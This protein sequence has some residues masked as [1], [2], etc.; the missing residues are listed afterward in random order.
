M[1]LRR[2]YDNWF[3]FLRLPETETRFSTLPNIWYFFLPQYIYMMMPGSFLPFLKT[4]FTIFSTRSIRTSPVHY[5]ERI[6]A[7]THK[8]NNLEKR[9]L[10]WT[11]KFKSIEEVPTYIAP[12]IMEKTRN[13]IRIRVANIMMA[14]TLVICLL[15]AISGKRARDSGDSVQKRNLD[16]HK[17]LKEESIAMDKKSQN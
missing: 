13:K 17:Q 7:D 15:V 8:V 9:F 2:T 11:K 14:G 3:I 1:T 12:E 10:V 16:W 6:R 5:D 4:S